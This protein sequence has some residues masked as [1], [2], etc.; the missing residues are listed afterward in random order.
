MSVSVRCSIVSISTPRVVRL[1]VII[2]KAR[3][4]PCHIVELVRERVTLLGISCILVWCLMGS[5]RA[6]SLLESVARRRKVGIVACSTFL[7]CC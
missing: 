7:W 3:I 2:L 5:R 1:V 6:F 4:S